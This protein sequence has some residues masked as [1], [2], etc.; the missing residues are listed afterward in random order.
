MSDAAGQP[1]GRKLPKRDVIVLPLLAL[2]TVVILGAGAELFARV[3]WPEQ[4]ADDCM[5]RDPIVGSHAKPNCTALTKA[6]EG[7][8]SEDRWND[9]GYRALGSCVNRTDGSARIVAVGSSTGWGY[10]VPLEDTWFARAASTL[11]ARCGR[12][13]DFQAL[14]GIANLYQNMARLPQ[15][16]Q[17]HPDAVV[18]ILSPFDIAGSNGHAFDPTLIGQPR[19]HV[20]RA[21]SH[22]IRAQIQAFVG[23]SRA[24]LV[25]QHY[26]YQN[27]DF[28]V[29]GYLASGEKA[30]YLR[31]PFTPVWQGR[32]AFVDKA[33]E[34]FAAQ[35]RSNDIPLIVVLAPQEAQAELA[36]GLPHPADVDPFAIGNAM[37]RMAA[38]D[39]FLFADATTAY[40]KASALQDMFLS[41]NGHFSSAGHAILADV[42]AATLALAEHPAGRR[43]C[44]SDTQ[45]PLR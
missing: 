25:A 26:L 11:H 22:S 35:L 10:L 39:G 32:L 15:I 9:C 8:W 7:I 3:Y 31:Q 28:Y 40:S 34:Y 33:L 17:L 43:L 4:E 21:G 20:E 44:G 18:M 12:E 14:G 29:S 6:A 16:L 37:A 23:A 2:L 5:I 24:V 42:A 38:R 41:V 13:F 45:A 36:A 27:V 30:D 1:P 19:E